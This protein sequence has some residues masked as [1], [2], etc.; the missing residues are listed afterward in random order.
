[1]PTYKEIPCACGFTPEHNRNE[2]ES[3]Q[4]K[5]GKIMGKELPTRKT[6][7][8]KHCKDVCIIETKITD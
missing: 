2:F 3:F 1:M 7:R 8:C 6:W 4:M 5:M